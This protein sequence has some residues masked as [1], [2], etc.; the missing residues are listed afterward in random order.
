VCGVCGESG[1]PGEDDAEREAGATIPGTLVNCRL[2]ELEERCICTDEVME[3]V[4]A[5]FD[6]FIMW[7][8]DN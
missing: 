4:R 3:S 7:N 8:L 5:L 6:S 1:F 2:E